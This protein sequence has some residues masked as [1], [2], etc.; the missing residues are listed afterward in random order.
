MLSIIVPTD[1]DENIYYKESLLPFQGHND[2]EII[3]IPQKEAFTRAERFN[4]GFHRSKGNLILFHHP[5]TNLPKEAIVYLIEKSKTQLIEWEWG[6]FLHSFDQKHFFLNWISWYSNEVRVRRKGIVYFD[7]CIFFQRNLW[8]EDLSPSYL[9]EDTE[10]SQNFL[11]QSKPVLLP[12][13]AVTSAHRFI[14]NGIYKQT[15]LNF[16]LKIG[17]Q[18]QLPSSFLFSLYQ[19]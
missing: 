7:H 17:N 16:I 18:L 2:V 15:L 14:K 3:L 1:I 19:K 11:K 9:F 8:K 5:R 6:G 10:L 13:Q 12:F 4:L